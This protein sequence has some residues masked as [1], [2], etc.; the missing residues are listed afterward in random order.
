[1]LSE[2]WRKNYNTIRPHSSWDADRL[3][4]SLNNL[5]F[6]ILPDGGWL[7]ELTSVKVSYLLTFTT[8]TTFTPPAGRRG[9]LLRAVNTRMAPLPF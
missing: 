1:M 3:L 7:E 2:W 9:N 5:D 6:P 4:R 8:F